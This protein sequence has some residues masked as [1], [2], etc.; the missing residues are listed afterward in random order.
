MYLMLKEFL[1]NDDDIKCSTPG[2]AEQCPV[3]FTLKRLLNVKLV[4]VNYV[5]IV[6]RFSNNHELFASTPRIV[7]D[8]MKRY[9]NKDLVEPIAFSLELE[10]NNQ[11]FWVFDDE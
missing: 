9:D 5:N 7:R 1:M 2:K 4:N 8:F 10:E 11:P 6:I 3:S